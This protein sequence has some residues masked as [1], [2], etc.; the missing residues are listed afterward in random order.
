MKSAVIL[1]IV[2]LV[3]LFVCSAD[4]EKKSARVDFYG[5][6]LPAGAIG[7]L[8]TVRMRHGDST[9][10]V[11]FSPTG[12]VF[13]TGGGRDGKIVLWDVKTG[14][15]VAMLTG[16]KSTV[17][18]LA[19]S[20]DGKTLA[21]GGNDRTV[22]L[23]N[24]ATGKETQRTAGKS[25]VSALVFRD[26]GKALVFASAANAYVWQLVRPKDDPVVMTGHKRVW[27]WHLSVEFLRGNNMIV[28]AGG[29]KTVRFWNAWTGKQTGQIDSPG[30][31]V[32][33][34][35]VSPDGKLLA[36]GCKDGTV[37]FWSLEQKKELFVLEGRKE[38]VFCLAF[39]PDGRTLAVNSGGDYT[40]R[41]WDLATKKEIRKLPGSGNKRNCLAFSPDGKTLAVLR[42]DKTVGLRDVKTGKPVHDFAGHTDQIYA[43][44][45]SPDGKRLASGAV[46]SALGAKAGIDNA[47]R[48]WDV[49]QPFDS[50]QDLR[51]RE[52]AKWPAH[53]T[54]GPNGL[55]W[56]PD[57]KAIVSC[58]ADNS[59]KMWDAQTGKS[60]RTFGPHTRFV[61]SVAV[62]P[63]GSIVATGGDGKVYLWSAATGKR[64]GKWEGNI[65]QN[66]RLAFSANGKALA[67]SGTSGIFIWTIPPG[68]SSIRCSGPGGFVPQIGFSPNGGFI[69]SAGHSGRVAVSNTTN[70]K[71]I[72]TINHAGGVFGVTFSPD[73]KLIASA[74]RDK[75]VRIWETATGKQVMN[76]TGHIAPVNAVAFS[77]DGKTLTS[78]G[79][80][81][82]ILLWSIDPWVQLAHQTPPAKMDMNKPTELWD[83][84][85]L[86][87]DTTADAYKV[88]WVLVHSG[89][90]AVDLL[91]KRL[92][93]E[94]IDREKVKRLIDDLDDNKY[95]VR[96]RAS[97]ELTVLGRVI[98]SDIREALKDP[99]SL[100][101]KVR[102]KAVLDVVSSP[103]FNTPESLRNCRSVQVLELI[104]TAKARRVLKKLAA[105]DAE[106]PLTKDAKSALARLVSRSQRDS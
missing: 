58:G 51:R 44:A 7:R 37:R 100:E 59:A 76:F 56:M 81:T 23:W 83:Q 11:A 91:D 77:L 61:T 14:K 15:R 21:S 89:D 8:G 32:G 62:S 30:G 104:G 19:F 13:A 55:A 47:I 79:A 73:G 1:I 101:A 66:A 24:V 39:S 38:I 95:A 49:R 12:K 43:L 53:G 25:N 102:L 10:S 45:F 3:L 97:E 28:S 92:K 82:T 72:I 106:A 52:I 68:E 4:A 17:A 99:T 35:A 94:R 46:S 6:P 18:C 103:L 34:V 50:A 93:P 29:D 57:G 86:A 60:I 74:G 26:D 54:R 70:G 69:L 87:G 88:M 64:F 22:R 48:I 33:S 20:P 67:G 16:H 98:E 80:D 42:A 75:T 90:K 84:L 65:G 36:Y 2:C 27:P 40:V 9:F 71:R 78:A 96:K 105:G 31:E 41:L 63:D 5:D 85:K